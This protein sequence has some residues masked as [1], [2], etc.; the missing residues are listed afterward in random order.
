MNNIFSGFVLFDKTQVS[1][2]EMD[3]CVTRGGFLLVMANAWFVNPAE[4]IFIVNK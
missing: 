3:A 2:L 1:R 4:K